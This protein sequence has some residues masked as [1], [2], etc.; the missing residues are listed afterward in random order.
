MLRF[1]PLQSAMKHN[2]T[3]IPLLTEI[4]QAYPGAAKAA[5]DH[6]RIILHY[7]ASRSMDLS[8]V[9]CL[10]EAHPGGAKAKDKNEQIALH[11]AVT[12]LCGMELIDMLLQYHKNGVLD[13]DRYNM[14]PLNYAVENNASVELVSTLID[15]N[16]LCARHVISGNR[17]VLHQA[18]EFRRDTEVV[19][20]VVEAW[21]GA[22]AVQES[23]QG[24]CSM[25]IVLC[26]LRFLVAQLGIRT[27]S[28]HV[29]YSTDLFTLILI[30][31]AGCP[32]T[33]QLR[34]CCR[35]PH[36]SVLTRP[37]L[38][39]EPLCRTTKVRIYCV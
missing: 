17:T 16:V 7:S 36:C 11:L 26:S 2:V 31:Q 25:L 37:T 20:V 28:H 8:F 15:A 3:D 18:V 27:T 1:L 23:V 21:P 38:W 5:D 33:G 34:G 10:L 32:C 24:E 39:T 6:G 22:C 4:L 19:K 9:K 35:C 14:V 12:R 30:T 13:V 29:S